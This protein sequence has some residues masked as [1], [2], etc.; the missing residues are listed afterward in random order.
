MHVQIF[1]PTF[2]RAKKLRRAVESV[3][4]QTVREVEVVVLDNHSEDETPAVV[5]ELARADSR[6]TYVRRA[7]N[8]GMV[9]NFNAIRQLVSGSHFTVLS[10]D[11]DYEPHFVATALDGFRRHSSVQF[12]AC[13]ALTKRGAVVVKSQLDTWRGGFYKAGSAVR[14]CLLGH[15]PLVT[16]CLFSAQVRE[17]FYFQP[18]LANVSDGFLLTCMFAKY[19]AFVTKKV[20]GHWYND[21]EN[22]SSVLTF[23]PVRIVNT[24]LCEYALYAEFARRHRLVAGGM[25]MLWFK[26]FFTVLVA[27]DRSDIDTVLS[28]TALGEQRASG[29][30]NLLRAA[31]AVRLVRVFVG[32]LR[33]FRRLNVV[34][35]MRAAARAP[36]GEKENP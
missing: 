6:V 12:V 34:V 15:Y 20:T 21:G 36:H 3:L 19:D 4:A 18:D 33:M 27:A 28:K 11:D 17:D 24:V 32:A 8:I 13:N 25:T 5:A 2:N 30:V 1:I 7:E 9:P 31:H 10:D 29:F 26:K 14:R 16:N 35:A 22:T 23:D